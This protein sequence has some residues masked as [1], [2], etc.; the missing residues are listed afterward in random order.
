MPMRGFI[1]IVQA[2]LR[3]SF[4]TLTPELLGAILADLEERGLDLDERNPDGLPD[5]E[6]IELLAQDAIDQLH[7]HFA[8]GIGHVYRAI[9]ARE[10]QSIRT[11][12]LGESWSLDE[13]RALPYNGQMKNF[14]RFCAEVRS[15]HVNW[16]ETVIRSVV[17]E[18][19]EVVLREDAP[20]LLVSITRCR[21][22]REED[23]QSNL[24]G[25]TL[26]A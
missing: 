10:M 4:V 1:E 12:A 15:E 16:R 11:H 13:E 26:R 19:Q 21:G 8:R 3:E 9:S 17:F 25:Q 14:F 5:T 23:V 24:V 22:G 18:E 20:V 2:P 6:I 7:G